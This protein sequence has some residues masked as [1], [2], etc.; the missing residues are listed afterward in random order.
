MEFDED[1]IVPDKALSFNEGGIAGY[2]PDSAWNRCRLEAL[3]SYAGF[4]LDEPLGKLTKK[5][6]DILFNGS[7]DSIK[8]VYEKQ[9]GSGYSSYDQKWPGLYADLRRRYRETYSEAQRV[10]LERLMAHRES[11]LRRPTL[12]AGSPRRDGRR[13]KHIRLVPAFGR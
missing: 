11:K 5:Q 6:K 7:K 3:A 10:S 13:Q 8:F 9:D 1:L 2:N 12:K 4:S